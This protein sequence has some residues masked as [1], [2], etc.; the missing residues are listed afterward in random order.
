[1]SKYFVQIF[2]G[3]EML[4]LKPGIIDDDDNSTAPLEHMQRVLWKEA[5]W[6][7]LKEMHDTDHCMGRTFANRVKLAYCNVPR[8][9][10]KLFTDTCPTCIQRGSASI[11][12]KAGYH[13]ILTHGFGSR[14][15]IDLINFQ[16]NAYGN[17]KSI[18]TYYDHGTK[19][20][21][22]MPLVCKRASS[23]AIALINIFTTFGPPMILQSD[24]G[25]EF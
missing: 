22:A 10:C 13:P 8:D 6:E 23:I 2:Q 21:R 24:N 20:A 25:R 1:M 18:L 19:L 12:P 17:F 15:Q 4:M 3:K 5:T 9:L 14:G 16:S 11:K 7:A